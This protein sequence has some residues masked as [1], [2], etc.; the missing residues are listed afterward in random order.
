MLKTIANE[1]IK[2]LI[3]TREVRKIGV[4]KKDNK[5]QVQSIQKLQI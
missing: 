3:K 4:E 1:I 5:E 2:C